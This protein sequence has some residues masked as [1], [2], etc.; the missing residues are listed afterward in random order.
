MEIGITTDEGLYSCV[1]A[2]RDHIVRSLTAKPE[3]NAVAPDVSGTTDTSTIAP[4]N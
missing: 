4:A 1:V 2:L 3:D